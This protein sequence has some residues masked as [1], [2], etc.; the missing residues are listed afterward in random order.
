M[1]GCGG[2]VTNGILAN[3]TWVE[4]WEVGCGVGAD[5]GA[6]AV[7]L[8]PGAGDP[9]AIGGIHCPSFSSLFSQSS[10]T[11]CCGACAGP[12]SGP[13]VIQISTEFNGDWIHED[14]IHGRLGS[15]TFI[16]DTRIQKTAYKQNIASK[17]APL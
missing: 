13:Q 2:G 14:W 12:G 16:E 7:W 6:A 15:W 10:P 9:C 3:R 1:W 4:T 5:G 8:V 11:Q 17:P